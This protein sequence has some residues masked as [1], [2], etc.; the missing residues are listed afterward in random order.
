MDACA[1]HHRIVGDCA[2]W[3][4]YLCMR[5]LLWN[6]R[7]LCTVRIESYHEKSFGPRHVGSK[8]FSFCRSGMATPKVQTSWILS[9]WDGDSEKCRWVVS[10]SFG[11]GRVGSKT[12]S[13]RDGD[14]HPTTDC[15]C[16]SG[17]TTTTLHNCPGNYLKVQL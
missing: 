1:N 3:D 8:T 9:L 14:I 2:S 4:C 10:R 12:L 16:R 5:Q 11:P 6:S 15:F 17:T 13:P 7:R